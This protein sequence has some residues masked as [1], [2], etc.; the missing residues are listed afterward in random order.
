MPP[1]QGDGL[2]DIGDLALDFRA[3]GADIRSDETSVK[4]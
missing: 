3:H 1:Q 4:T 2:L